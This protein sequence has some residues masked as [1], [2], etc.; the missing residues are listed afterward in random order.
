MTTSKR[1][2][3]TKNFH[4]KV[5]V[6]APNGDVTTKFYFTKAQITK[7][8]GISSMTIHR[9]LTKPAHKLLKRYEHL[10]F[11]KICE[12]ARITVPLTSPGAISSSVGP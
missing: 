1:A 7:E 12:P 4:Y 3:R 8:Y 10:R 9:S 11:M 5:I 2:I 6:T